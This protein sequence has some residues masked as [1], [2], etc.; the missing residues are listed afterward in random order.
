[1]SAA[2]TPELVHGWCAR[3]VEQELP[4]LALLSMDVEV[5]RPG[6]VFQNPNGTAPDPFH[7][8]FALIP[9]ARGRMNFIPAR[10][11]PSWG[12]YNFRVIPLGP[13]D[14][15]LGRFSNASTL[16]LSPY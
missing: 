3:E 13:G 9:G 6:F 10:D 15:A 4:G 11:L 14:Q 1:M 2:P 12:V 7:L 8:T 5:S 16:V